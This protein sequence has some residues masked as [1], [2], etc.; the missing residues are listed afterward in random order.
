MELVSALSA[1]LSFS[2]ILIICLGVRCIKRR[3]KTAKRKKAADEFAD[4]TQRSEREFAIQ[5]ISSQFNEQNNQQCAAS[6]N[7]N[8]ALHSNLSYY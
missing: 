3:I 4:Q 8:I 7:I 2:L 5:S 1:V 6:D